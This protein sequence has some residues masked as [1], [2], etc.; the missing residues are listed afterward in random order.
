[1]EE[2][3]VVAETVH[4]QLAA[5]QTPGQVCIVG[6]NAKIREEVQ[7]AL[8][9]RGISHTDLRQDADYESDHVKVSTNPNLQKVTSSVPYSSWA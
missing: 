8:T 1:M 5:G 4:F 6:P 3:G 9:L 7:R 2:A